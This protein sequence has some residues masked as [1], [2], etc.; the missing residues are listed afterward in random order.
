MG[1]LISRSVLCSV[2]LV[3]LLSILQGCAS[4]PRFVTGSTPAAA[5]HPAVQ[6]PAG[7]PITMEGIA[8]YYAHD[9]QGK[10]TAN[11]E[12]YNMY[13]MTAAHRSLP[14][15][16]KVKVTNVENKRS[17]IVRVNDRGPFKLERLIDV[18]LAAATQLG[19]TEKGTARVKLEVV[20]WG[21]DE[22][23]K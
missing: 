6:P 13:Q 11:G 20:E 3:L 5:V 10:K 14:F 18:S 8:S 2:I 12:I 22:Y 17:I 1:G 19:M 23:V 16:T 4:A 21:N 9:F 7:A 15:G